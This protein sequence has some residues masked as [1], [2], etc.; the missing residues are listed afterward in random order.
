[1]VLFTV[2]HYRGPHQSALWVS[3]SI[4]SADPTQMGRADRVRC[5]YFESAC[6]HQLYLN[7]DRNVMLM[8]ALKSG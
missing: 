7:F 4:M 3:F 6:C 2:R 8:D 1:M 5:Q